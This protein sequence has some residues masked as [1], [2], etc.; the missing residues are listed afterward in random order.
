MLTNGSE[1]GTRRSGRPEPAT[2]AG[3][4]EKK[5]ALER[6]AAAANIQEAKA[7]LVSAAVANK[8]PVTKDTFL[9]HLLKLAAQARIPI[10]RLARRRKDCLF[11]F[12]SENPIILAALRNP[13]AANDAKCGVDIDLEV[14]YS[15]DEDA[16]LVSLMFDPE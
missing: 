16:F 4:F 2:G 5:R 11:C 7:A 9:K 14:D 8:Q 15:E 10:D 13:T 1:R 3:R 12:V 6:V